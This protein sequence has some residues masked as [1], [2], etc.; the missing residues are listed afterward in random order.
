MNKWLEYGLLA[1]AA[2]AVVIMAVILI[3]FLRA[4]RAGSPATH[5][6]VARMLGTFARQNGWRVLD[7]PELTNDDGTVITADHLLL[8]QYGALVVCDLHRKGSYYGDTDSGEWVISTGDEGKMDY[9]TPAVNQL[10]RARDF[11]KALR[12]VMEKNKVY[13]VQSE[14]YVARSEGAF[15]YITGT[16]GVV[17]SLADLKKLLRSAKYSTGKAQISAMLALPGLK[18]G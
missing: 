1:A 5:N 2:A 12:R 7:R 14:S 8:C 16:R 15:V 3:R 11:E 18:E 13:Y 6:A 9:R 10:A 17:L 4:N